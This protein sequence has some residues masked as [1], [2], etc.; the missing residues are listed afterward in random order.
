M[1]IINFR[2]RINLS[3]L[4]LVAL[5]ALQ[6]NV[7]FAIC[8]DPKQRVQTIFTRSDVAFIGTVVSK[9]PEAD[10]EEKIY[11]KGYYFGLKVKQLFR[12]PDKKVI[13]VYE[14]NDS[15][16]M[17][18]EIGHTYLIFV[19]KQKDGKF[20]GWCDDAR[21]IKTMDDE[22]NYSLQIDEVN[23]N[24]K[25]GANGDIQGVVLI[26]RKYGSGWG[27]KM[28]KDQEGMKGIH[29]TIK[30]NGK[31]YKTV[32]DK[33]G[34]FHVSVPEGHYK[35]EPIELKRKISPTSYS[36]DDPDDVDVRTA[37]GGELEFVVEPIR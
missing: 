16:R 33:E 31:V 10:P 29:F 21:E 12:G 25:I 26:G 20:Q 30:G 22:K 36:L 28:G 6:V 5:C 18:L 8:P 32:S 13:E 34:W 37:G 19:T 17:G 11:A 24:I 1:R 15:A 2:N 35:V 7:S 3:F 27:Y 23:K 14:D 9:R 4:F